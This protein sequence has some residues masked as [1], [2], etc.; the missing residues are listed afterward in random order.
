MI[1]RRHFTQS[2]SALAVSASTGV[3][4]ASSEFSIVEAAEADAA[5]QITPTTD[6]S[7]F[8]LGIIGSGSR[9]QEL[10]RSFLRVPG[11]SVAAAADVYEP[12]FAQLNRICGHEVTAHKDYRALLDRKDLD[13]VIVATPLGL[14]G[15]HVVA[16]LSS[17]HAVYG[18]KV[19]GLHGRTGKR[20]RRRCE[21]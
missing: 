5:R 7:P 4:N 12:R 18:E 6:S 17:G 9:G 10:I 16:A 20:H 8:R 3:L 14:H 13:A 1:S 11:V 19:D 15:E 2:L 21:R